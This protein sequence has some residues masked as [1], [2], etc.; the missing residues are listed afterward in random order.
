MIPP[1]RIVAIVLAAG[2]STRLGAFKPLLL[3]PPGSEHAV[4]LI[5]YQLRQLRA[6]GI[7]ECVVVTGHRSEEV[8]QAI[9]SMA[10]RVV[11]NQDYAEGKAGS[12]RLGVAE[13]SHGWFLVV[14]VDQPR[15]ASFYRT[16]LAAVEPDRQLALPTYGGKRGHPPLFHPSLRKALLGV[17]EDTEGMRA[18]VR[19]LLPEAQL[20]EVGPLSL[21][22]LNAA[23]DLRAVEA[24]TVW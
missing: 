1:E 15:P 7:A 3:W 5:V 2:S 16:F 24:D 13:A 6:A 20:V 12:V 9:E 19:R 22:D 8:A 10:P 21:V 18:V 17:T 4:P 11:W 14:G 23:A